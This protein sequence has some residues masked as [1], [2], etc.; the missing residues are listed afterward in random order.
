MVRRGEQGGR[1]GKLI[2]GGFLNIEIWNSET[3]MLVMRGKQG[4]R[5]TTLIGGGFLNVEIWNLETRMQ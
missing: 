1:R 2:G 3:R 4:G 5:I